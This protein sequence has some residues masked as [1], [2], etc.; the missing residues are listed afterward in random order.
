MFRLCSTSP[1][2]N[3]M[4]LRLTELREMVRSLLERGE[5][6]TLQHWGSKSE[7]PIEVA[8]AR[9]GILPIPNGSG[10]STVGEG[11]INSVKEV[12]YRGR[13]CVARYS[14]HQQEQR[15]MIDFVDSARLVDPKYAKHFPELIDTFEFEVDFHSGDKTVIY[16]TLV[17]LLSPMPPS[18]LH[19]IQQLPWNS[20]V[21]P[22]RIRLFLDDEKFKSDLIRRTIRAG[23]YGTDEIERT[24]DEFLVPCLQRVSHGRMKALELSSTLHFN[25]D[26][27]PG[28]RYMA[29]EVAKMIR[30]E[31]IP[32]TRGRDHLA[33][34][35]PHKKVQE[36]A[37]FL[38]ALGEAGILYDDLHTGN[39]MVR[40]STGDFVIVD[41]GYFG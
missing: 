21:S 9:M 17:E 11:T 23:S 16:G 29:D 12:L 27:H 28:G 25:L 40:R 35:H 41:P 7:D 15:A 36:F 3:S 10:T 30:A 4:K 39:F 31:V 2:L 1:Y 5:E 26:D 6:S 24:F 13:R 20:T 8:L 22:S 38:Q 18:L 37:E 14:H 19:D 33:R 32:L 34:S